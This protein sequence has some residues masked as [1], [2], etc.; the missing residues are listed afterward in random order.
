MC[1]AFI[2]LVSSDCAAPVLRHRDASLAGSKA[3][4]QST[5]LVDVQLIVVA[6]NWNDHIQISIIVNVSQR[7]NP[8]AQANVGEAWLTRLALVI[9]LVPIEVAAHEEI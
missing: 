2:N 6:P 8:K 3:S 9:S 7:S 1:I 4:A 5:M